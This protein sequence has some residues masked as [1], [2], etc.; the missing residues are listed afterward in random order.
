MS[1]PSA[2]AFFSCGDVGD[3]GQ[4]AQLD[5]AVVG[6]DQLVAGRRR[7]RRGGSCGPPRCGPGCS[8][9][10]G[11]SR[12]AAPWW[13]R[14]A[15]RRYGRAGARVDSLAGRR[16]RWLSAWRAGAS[17][18]S[19]RQLVAFRG[20]ILQHARR[21]STRRRWRSSC[22]RAGPSG[23]TGCRRSAWAAEIERPA[24]ERL[25]L[26][27]DARHALARIR[28]R[29]ARECRGRSAMPRASIAPARHQRPLQ[30]LVD[31]RQP[32]AASRGFS[33]SHRRSVTSASSAA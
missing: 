12:R 4:Q 18:A 26:G 2:K 24:D 14:P 19:S 11:R 3:V 28:P 13:S 23:R 8:A 33:A 5:L 10:W 29:G 17:P 9:G 20:Q 27:L 6:G 7:R 30:R 15:R 21:R 25:D 22:R 1:R 16:C 32:S 31:R